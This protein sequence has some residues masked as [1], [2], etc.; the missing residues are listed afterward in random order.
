MHA[1][2]GSE[3]ERTEMESVLASG[4]FD[5]S[6]R[7]GTFFRYICERHL[8]GHADEIKEYSIA[9]EALGRP[10]TFDPKK[11]SI[12]RVE[13]HRLR[14]R[15]EEYYRGEGAHHPIHIV[16]P[17]GQYR[18]QFVPQSEPPEPVAPREE[19]PKPAAVAVQTRPRWHWYSAALI[20][21]VIVVTGFVA[22]RVSRRPAPVAH[23]APAPSAPVENEVWTGPATEV[24]QGDFR[25]LAGYHGPRFT[26]RQGHTW[27]ADAY[28]TGGQSS[29]IPPLHLIEGQPDPLLIR[30]R[31]CGQFRYDIPLRPGNYELHL[32]FA[33]TEFGQGNPGGGG[34]STRVFQVSINDAVGI[35]TMDPLAEAGAPNRL[36]VR[37]FR[38]ISPAADGKLHLAFHNLTGASLL[39]FI[40]LL[41]SPPGRIH[42][43]RIVAQSSPVTDSDGRLWAADEYSLGGTLVFRRNQVA[44]PKEEDLYQGEHYGN[45]SYHI[46]LAPGK[47][48]LTL[49]FAETWFG[50]PESREPALN[51]RI[52][53]V[54]ANG[55]VLLRDFQIAKNAGGPN[56]SLVKVFEN[57]EPNAQGILRLEFVPVR[58]YAEV[59]AIEVVEMN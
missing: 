12:V 5:K 45:F 52:F 19:V 13:A 51:S 47:Y 46:P 11:D 30:A 35:A 16:I 25:M 56:R 3:K 55:T 33:E 15:L 24:A 58:N 14:K 1:T 54:F 40:E 22:A 42:P 23:H 41:P 20:F 44:S 37:V 59:N 48:R 4:L 17:N 57:L 53:N 31:R 21:L 34:D 7:L 39:N 10:V 2:L 26:D 8:E 28:Y 50:M 18:P 32:G 9:L 49:H 27:N 6:P 36:H 43:V 29:A 38:N